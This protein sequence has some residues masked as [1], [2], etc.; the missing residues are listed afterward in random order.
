M[1]ARYR[2]ALLPLFLSGISL[3]VL[4][5]EMTGRTQLKA[6]FRKVAAPALEAM[7]VLRF[8]HCR[9]PAPGPAGAAE[10]AD[11]AYE[12]A[13]LRYEVRLLREQ[14]RTFRSTRESSRTAFRFLTARVLYLTGLEEGRQLAVVDLGASDGIRQGMGVLRGDAAVGRVLRCA[15][16]HAVIRFLTDPGCK[17]PATLLPWGRAEGPEAEGEKYEGLLEGRVGWSDE[18]QLKHIHRTVGVAVSDVVLTSG[19]LGAFPPGLVA[20]NVVSVSGEEFSQF[21]AIRLRPVCFHQ[22]LPSVVIAVPLAA[23]LREQVSR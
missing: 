17:V 7:D 14:V 18:V 16:E 2:K 9:R 22:T 12:C 19:R 4:A 11:V 6:G 15:P 3:L 21:H 1:K 13:R 5:G 10:A 23:E 8:A 20:G